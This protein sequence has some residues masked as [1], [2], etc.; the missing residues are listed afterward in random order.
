[1]NMALKCTRIP[2]GMLQYRK[3]ELLL[4]NA[5]YF[6]RISEISDNELINEN[7]IFVE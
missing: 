4:K 1:M 3:I 7:A 2:I 5:Y 6:F